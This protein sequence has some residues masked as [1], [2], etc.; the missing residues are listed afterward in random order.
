MHHQNTAQVAISVAIVIPLI[1]FEELPIS[2][3]MREA[4]VTN[5]NPNTMTKSAAR[6]FAKAPV[7]A[8]GMG[9][10]L[11]SAH[12]IARITPSPP[13]RIASKIALGTLGRRCRFSLRAHV[14]QT[15]GQ[16]REDRRQSFN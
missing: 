7:C 4:T 1:G 3:L 6:K 14:L 15:G 10:N 11:R 8:P 13:P 9:L 12:I 2:P 5:K 16:G